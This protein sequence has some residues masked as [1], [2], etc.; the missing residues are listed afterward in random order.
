MWSYGMDI[1]NHQ[2][3]ID[4]LTVNDSMLG[5]VYMLATDG[6][7]RGRPNGAPLSIADA[8][9]MNTA[10]CEKL[11]G[12]YTFARPHNTDPGNS[13]RFSFEV[14]GKR[15]LPHCL[16]LEEYDNATFKSM[17]IG[18]I[19]EWCNEW[20]SVMG[21]L[22]GR[23]PIIY[24]GS[25]FKGPGIARYFPNHFWWIPSYTGNSTIDPDPLRLRNPNL[26]GNREPDMW[27]YTSHGRVQGVTGNVDKNL[28]LTDKLLSLINFEGED[29]SS[30]DEIAQL[31]KTVAGSAI[32]HVNPHESERIQYLAATCPDLIGPVT[33]D[34]VPDLAFQVFPDFTM[35]QRTGDEV[36]QLVFIGVPDHG[37]RNDAWW[38]KLRLTS[39]DVLR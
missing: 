32:Y 6:Y 23:R 18:T 20:L 39:R 25:F 34:T 13:A 29:M 36:G 28:V 24:C 31:I 37:F 14:A 35:V 3:V 11:C 16:D 17:S 19:V 27:Q 8:Y 38:G 5:F 2:G 4:W 9:A 12:P 7:W 15:D 30:M 1:S 22:E 33:S 26:N 21:T 10:H